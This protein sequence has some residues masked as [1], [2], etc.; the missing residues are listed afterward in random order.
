MR[1]GIRSLLL[2][3]A[4]FCACGAL[5]N[6]AGAAAPEFGRCVKHAGGN[7]ANARCTESAAGTGAWEWEPGPGPK[8]GFAV[9]LT[10]TAGFLF[11]LATHAEGKCTGASAIGEYTG[12]KTV[13]DVRMSFTGCV[14][15][16]SP[17]CETITVAPLDGELGVYALGET[18]AKDK[19]GLKLSPESG[20]SLA[21]FNCE[22]ESL[23]PYLWRG[24]FVIA[25]V[26]ANAMQLTGSWKFKQHTTPGK[27][28]E[29]QIPSSFVGEPA[30][31]LESTGNGTNGM[32][33]KVYDPMGW[34]MSTAVHNE[35][36]IEANSVF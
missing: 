4:I 12:A 24:G 11:K 35:E 22:K 16:G 7:F 30:S 10:G 19:L 13:A 5:A 32:G 1:T 9:T 31:P 8:R 29:E 6:A 21:S 15:A 2:G 3:A 14:Y 23:S 18:P 20:T 34:S 36:K 17:S 26:G 28:G 25:A 33:E 27:Y